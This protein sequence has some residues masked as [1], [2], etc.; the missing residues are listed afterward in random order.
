MHVI[1]RAKCVHFK[2]RLLDFFKFSVGLLSIDRRSP[3][4]KQGGGGLTK[5]FVLK[6]FCLLIRYSLSF[7]K[8]VI[9]R[10]RDLFQ[11]FRLQKILEFEIFVLLS[12]SDCVNIFEGLFLVASVCQY[13]FFVLDIQRIVFFSRGTKTWNGRK[14][15]KV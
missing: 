9:R 3:L 14:K 8:K 1:L 2:E 10:F 5:F 7:V 11:C 6:V 4:G 12:D 13:F 15:T